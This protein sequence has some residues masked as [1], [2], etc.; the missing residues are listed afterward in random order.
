MFAPE[1]SMRL[2]C[3]QQ[4][5]KGTWRRSDETGEKLQFE[6]LEKRVL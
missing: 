6:R 3:C 4:A 2:L 1:F 5:R